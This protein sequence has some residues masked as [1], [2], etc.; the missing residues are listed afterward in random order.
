MFIKA[1]KSILTR[2]L[3]LLL[4]IA[5]V[6]GVVGCSA[7]E[8]GSV[9]ELAVSLVGQDDTANDRSHELFDSQ[10]DIGTQLPDEDGYYSS[11]DDVALYINTYGCLPKNYITKDE[12]RDLGWSGGSLEEYA[13][14]FAIGGDRFGNREGLLPEKNGRYYT[15]CDIDTIGSDSRGAK[16]IVFSNDGLIY[17]TED[18][19]ESFTLLYGDEQT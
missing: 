14:G 12:A 1:K 19:Y 11:R 2:L 6:I 3:A 9:I 10:D 5:A 13:K 17:Y 16:R 15:E 18:H 4:I 7:D 8:L